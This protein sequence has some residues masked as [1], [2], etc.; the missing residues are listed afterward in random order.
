[1]KV[2]PL[3]NH[4]MFKPLVRAVTIAAVLAAAP[5]QADDVVLRMKDGN[6]QVEGTLLSF[7]GTTYVIASKQVGTMS[8]FAGRFDC[9]GEACPRGIAKPAAAQ[10]QA[11]P[12]PD[13]PPVEASSPRIALHAPAS[14]SP[15]LLADLVKGWIASIGG[16]AVREIGAESGETRLRA[17]DRGGK[18]IA[19]FDVHRG[20]AW[21]AFAALQA[22]AAEIVVTDRRIGDAEAADLAP[23]AGDMRA[24]AR[25]AVVALDAFAVIVAPDNPVGS[26]SAATMAR[27]FGGQV[28][29]WAELGLPAG[30]IA[31]YGSATT[32]G[33]GSLFDTEILKPQGKVLAPAAVQMSSSAAVAEAV[34]QQRGGIGVASIADMRHA[35]P[36]GIDQGCGL[37]TEASAFAIKTE[38]YPLSRR[39]Y[40]YTARTPASEPARKLLEFVA[41]PDGQ[42]IIADHVLVDQRLE[43]SAFIDHRPR[44]AFAQSRP[45]AALPRLLAELGAASR[46]ST[47]IRFDS[48]T[49]L[50]DSKSQNE[51]KGVVALLTRPGEPRRRVML[52][53]FSDVVGGAVKNAALAAKRAD[54]ARA[55]LIAAAAG[56]LD[57]GLLVAKGYE[58][59]APVACDDTERGRQLNRRVELWVREEPNANR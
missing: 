59:L 5:A 23:Q 47:T 11:A 13:K 39:I 50:I 27:I 52:L 19:R 44:F 7:D 38:E 34:A 14:I 29:D 42:D 10:Q 1:M 58:T 41:S 28:V 15:T 55:A 45:N 54:Q 3:L 17:I 30:R 24:A 49:S 8:L 56:A 46:L 22:G 53:G 48:G 4:S 20:E 25:E 12:S 33:P 43:T 26:M 6:F 32:T 35:K 40:L 57:P 36:V 21:A 9:I 31:V 18:E 2:G 16:S 51:L 37:L